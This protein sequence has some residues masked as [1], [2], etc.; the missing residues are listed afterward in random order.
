[1]RITQISFT[2]SMKIASGCLTKFLAVGEG[3]H[4]M[5]LRSTLKAVLS[6]SLY[7]Q[8]HIGEGDI[9][10]LTKKLMDVVRVYQKPTPLRTETVTHTVGEISKT[11]KTDIWREEARITGLD[12]ETH[13]SYPLA[14]KVVAD[15]HPWRQ[16][17]WKPIH[18][19]QMR[20]FTSWFDQLLCWAGWRS[21]VMA[22]IDPAST[23]TEKA[24]MQFIRDNPAMVRKALGL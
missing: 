4:T 2:M 21:N 24:F 17:T 11:T 15:D 13:S 6:E 3:K 19:L 20:P 16:F 10:A 22:T 18:G 14:E 9:E 7:D 8:S 23:P 1:M 12:F 5:S